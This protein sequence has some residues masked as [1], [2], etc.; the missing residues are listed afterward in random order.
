MFGAG[1]DPLVEPLT[2][3]LAAIAGFSQRRVRERTRTPPV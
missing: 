3:R 1:I 2:R